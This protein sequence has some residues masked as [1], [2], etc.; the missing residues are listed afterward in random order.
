MWLVLELG[1]LGLW[2]LSTAAEVVMCIILVN[3]AFALGDLYLMNLHRLAAQCVYTCRLLRCEHVLALAQ[4]AVLWLSLDTG[5][6]VVAA[7]VSMYAIAETVTYV[8]H[9]L[10]RTLEDDDAWKTSASFI[11]TLRAK[12]V[13]HAVLLSVLLLYRMFSLPFV[14]ILSWLL[15]FVDFNYITRITR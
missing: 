1:L 2:F 11:K 14:R 9:P 3:A 6:L 10:T 5:K 12:A 13:F 15:R 8:R 4:A 7:L